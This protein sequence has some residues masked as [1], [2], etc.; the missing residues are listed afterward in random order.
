MRSRLA[1]LVAVFVAGAAACVIGPKQDDPLGNDPTTI[2]S[3]DTGTAGGEGA[4]DGTD[5][6]AGA[7]SADTGTARESGPTPDVGADTTDSA[8][9]SASDSTSDSEDAAET[10]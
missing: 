1:V 8:N 4:Y 7:S 9:D 10:D 3:S 5:A 6:E 2:P